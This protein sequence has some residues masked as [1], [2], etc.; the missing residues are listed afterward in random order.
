MRLRVDKPCQC[1]MCL[2]CGTVVTRIDDKI[3]NS[4]DIILET[5]V[6]RLVALKQ[7]LSWVYGTVFRKI[8]I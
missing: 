5:C 4:K 2:S 1:I 3:I 8:K 6:G 7:T